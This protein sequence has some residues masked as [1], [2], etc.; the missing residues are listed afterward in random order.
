MRRPRHPRT[1]PRP[2]R[3]APASPSSPTQSE[4]AIRTAL[5]HA[6]EHYPIPVHLDGTQLDRR[7]FLDGAVHAEKW[8]GIVFGVFDRDMTG[9]SSP[10]LNFHGLTLHARLPS[11]ETIDD[12]VWSVRADIDSAPDLEL[13]L[14]ARKELVETPFA[15]DMRAAARTAIYRAMRRADRSPSLPYN[16][17]RRARDAGIDMQIAAAVLRPWRP[18]TADHNDWHNPARPEPV[19][20][21]TLVMA[22]DLEPQDAQALWRAL[23]RAGLQHRVFEADPRCEGYSWYDSLARLTAAAFDIDADGA[24]HDLDSMRNPGDGDPPSTDPGHPVP[25]PVRTKSTPASL[26]KSPTGTP[27]P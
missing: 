22:A 24:S 13:V 26:S 6:V 21:S 17:Y 1:R 2:C 8:N 4:G 23:E 10:D 18:S 7:A 27:K 12:G 3:T 9:F 16:H 19:R 14:P 5:S 20:P 11:V 25:S 15:S